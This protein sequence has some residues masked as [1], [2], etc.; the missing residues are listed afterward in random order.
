MVRWRQAVRRPGD[1]AVIRA[2]FRPDVYRAA[3]AGAPWE[4]DPMAAGP[5]IEA[6]DELDLFDH[7]PF[8]PTNI[9]AYLA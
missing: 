4:P 6:S 8:D 3:L 1:E 5:G 9:D 2:I 7:R